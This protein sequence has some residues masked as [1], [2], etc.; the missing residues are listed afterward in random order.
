MSLIRAIQTARQAL[1][2]NTSSLNIAGENISNANTD[3]FVR[4]KVTLR[5]ESGLGSNAYAI[6]S[7]IGAGVHVQSIERVTDQL[8]MRNAREAQSGFEGAAERHRLLSTLESLVG[9]TSGSTLSDTAHRFFDQWGALTANPR[10]P[11]VRN[12]VLGSAQTLVDHVNTLAR[13]SAEFEDELTQDLGRLSSRANS[14]IERFG[15][16]NET[17][18]GSRAQGMSDLAS[19]DERDRVV[20]ELAKL[21]PVSVR[22]S[23]NGSATLLSGSITLADG[24]HTNRLSLEAL[25]GQLP[26]IKAGEQVLASKE[27]QMGAQLGMLRTHLPAYRQELNQFVSSLVTQVNALHEVGF[28]AQ[29]NSGQPF[30]DPAGNE[31]GSLRLSVQSATGIAAR[32]QTADNGVA[33]QISGLRESI[34]RESDTL[35]TRIGIEGGRARTEADSQ[36]TVAMHLE[37]LVSS[38]QKVSMDEELAL[39]IRHQQ[40]YNAS[41]RVLTT[42]QSMIDTLLSL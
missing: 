9:T 21:L 8:L 30:F 22:M 29:G 39:L 34:V 26:Q 6:S 13:R 18:M 42:A 5:T 37:A 1:M 31:A 41:A 15:M 4:R 17:I 25:P 12:A 14:L 36:R 20:S 33:L 35:L 23:D 16:L 40:S 11:G 28:D 24:A 2:A 38:V 32:S 19:E 10:D 3:G 7:P 27:G